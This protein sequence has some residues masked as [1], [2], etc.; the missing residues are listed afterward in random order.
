MRFVLVERADQ[1]LPELGPPL[2]RRAMSTLRNRGIEIRLGTTVEQ[3]TAATVRLSDGDT[4][5]SHTVIWAAGVTVDPVV[6]RLGLPLH[7]GRLR[8]DTTL[9]VPGADGVY[10]LG[11]AAA[12]PD[13]TRPGRYTAPTA[14]HAQRQGRTAARNVAA[15]LGHGVA[16]PYRHRDLGLVVDLGPFSAVARPLGVPLWG[17]VAALVTRGYHLLALPSGAAQLRVLTDWLLD[18]VLPP[19]LTVVD[20]ED[21]ANRARI[22]GGSISR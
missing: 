7:D 4:V 8:V 3:V 16:R 10:A 6:T 5:P 21:E 19:Q 17:P 2:S 9:R 13:L 11:D 14:Q 1:V 15:S 18:L 12:V 20:I 22:P